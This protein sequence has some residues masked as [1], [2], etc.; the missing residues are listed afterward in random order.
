MHT[1]KQFIHNQTLILFSAFIKSSSI[2]LP[3]L[4]IT[5]STNIFTRITW[6]NS[7][8]LNNWWDKNII[9]IFTVRNESGLY[10]FIILSLIIFTTFYGLDSANNKMDQK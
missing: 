7:D 3:Y 1:S 2:L 4:L 8:K 10:F 5:F 6:I 9:E